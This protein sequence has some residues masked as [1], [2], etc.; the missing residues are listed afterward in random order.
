MLVHHSIVV[1][2]GLRGKNTSELIGYWIA[3][4]GAGL[5]PFISTDR[6]SSHRLRSELEARIGMLPFSTIGTWSSEHK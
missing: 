5:V 2:R 4:R 3:S 1:L 6:D